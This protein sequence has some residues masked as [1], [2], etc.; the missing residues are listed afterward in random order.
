MVTVAELADRVLD[1]RKAAWD[2]SGARTGIAAASD[3]GPE[4]ERAVRRIVAEAGYQGDELEVLVREV[5]DRVVAKVQAL[6][7]SVPADAA[8]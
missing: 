3:L 4:D 1:D 6:K 5:C 8:D 7:D 2:K